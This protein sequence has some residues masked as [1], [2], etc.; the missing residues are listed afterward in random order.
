MLII[1]KLS[2]SAA[3]SNNWKER[4]KPSLGV[5]SNLNIVFASKRALRAQYF[6][7]KKQ[8]KN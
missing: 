1:G 3:L 6:N 4:I 7:L 5:I 8:K 2:K